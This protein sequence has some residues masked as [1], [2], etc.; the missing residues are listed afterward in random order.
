MEGFTD[1][2]FPFGPSFSLLISDQDNFDDLRR[3]VLAHLKL[4]KL[5][6][7]FQLFLP[8]WQGTAPM[9]LD[10]LSDFNALW[11]ANSRAAPLIL[12]VKK[13]IPRNII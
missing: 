1:L 11:A 2:A 10:S 9:A 13:K 12:A 3:A 6:H 8:L 4:E 7:P 5:L